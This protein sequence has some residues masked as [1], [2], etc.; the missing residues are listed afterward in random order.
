MARHIPLELP[1]VLFTKYIL[2]LDA[3]EHNSKTHLL[4]SDNVQSSTTPFCFPRRIKS[5]VVVFVVVVGVVVVD[6]FVF[7][8]VVVER[9]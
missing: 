9:K 2:P 7:D 4:L 5:V 3:Y 1:R 8:V 6:V